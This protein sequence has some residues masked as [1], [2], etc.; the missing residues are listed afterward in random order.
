MRRKEKYDEIV[1]A[2]GKN[3]KT[4]RNYSYI[5]G[6]T[7]SRRR[8]DLSFSHHAE[9]ASLPANLQEVFLQLAFEDKL[10]VRQLRQGIKQFK[11]RRITRNN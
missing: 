4:I 6:S 9:V 7:L 1:E 8:D 3:R 11:I 5:S 10:S 2:T